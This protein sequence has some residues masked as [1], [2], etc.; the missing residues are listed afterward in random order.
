MKV[1]SLASKK[2]ADNFASSLRYSPE[3]LVPTVAVDSATWEVLMLAYSNKE[4]VKR[5]LTSGEAWFF[6]RSRNSLWKKGE[7]SGNE[8]RV[9]SVSADCDTDALLYSVEVRGQG[10]AC[11]MGR[12]SCFV[13]KFGKEDA[14]FTIAQLDAIIASRLSEKKPGSYTVKLACSKKL[15]IAK[16][17]EE[18][19]EL[20]E[21]LEKKGRKEINWEACDLLYHALVAV[22]ARG[23]T[24]AELERELGRRNAKKK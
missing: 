24:L 3:G 11:H 9:L 18:G 5:T 1:K 8:M 23:I 22:R 13:E 7:T 10:N 19:E 4:A 2:Q 21:A 14:K 12:K 16:I 6:S 20:A 17:R 15:A